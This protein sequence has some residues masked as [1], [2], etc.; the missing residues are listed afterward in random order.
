MLRRHLHDFAR[1]GVANSEFIIRGVRL[2]TTCI[3][4]EARPFQTELMHEMVQT[5][6]MFL[7]GK[8]MY[9]LT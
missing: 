5:L 6:V 9:A 3:L 2:M 8:S 1:L 4:D 7:Q